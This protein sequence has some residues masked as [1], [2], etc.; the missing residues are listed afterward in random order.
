MTVTNLFCALTLLFTTSMIAQEAKKDE[1]KIQE[2]INLDADPK[3]QVA[4]ADG[5]IPLDTSGAKPMDQSEILKRA[6]NFVKLET[7]KYSKG[8]GVTT[9][10]KAEFLATFKYKPKELNPQADVEGSFSMHV[11]IEAKQGKYRYSISKINHVARNADFSGG[12]IYSE[13]PKCGSMKLPS[14]MWKL[15]R[16]EAIKQAMVIAGE[17]KDAMKVPSNA[18][19]DKDEW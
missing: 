4:L 17:I 6:I 18:K 9:A 12:D 16:S 3:P 13:V 15:M 11:S 2:V 14:A 8:N 7:T 5:S 19:V 10:S 1:K